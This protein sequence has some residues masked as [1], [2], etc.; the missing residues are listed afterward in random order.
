M[1]SATRNTS[2]AITNTH[3][4]PIIMIRRI[5]IGLMGLA[6]GFGLST[7]AGGVGSMTVRGGLQG[8]PR[9]EA[10]AQAVVRNGHLR[11]VATTSIVGDVVSRVGGDAVTI[12]VLIGPGRDPHTYEPTPRGMA[13][14]S[15]ADMV[16]ANGAGLEDDLADALTRA[17]HGSIVEVSDGVPLLA[18]DHDGDR[19]AVGTQAVESGSVRTPDP[20]T[21]MS[22]PNV[23]IWVE[24]IRDAL[25]TMDPD[26][27]HRYVRNAEEYTRE[28]DLLDQWIRESVGVVDPARRQLVSDH[29]VFAYFADEY[30]FREMGFVV[31]GA[32][33][34]SEVSS[35]ALADLV[36]LIRDHRITSIFVGVSAGDRMLGLVEAVAAETGHG[37][38]VV[39]I[40]SG[41]LSIPGQPGD[42]YLDFMRLN[43]VRIVDALAEE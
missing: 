25:S 23:K 22:P 10:P 29:R 19:I 36:E 15:D 34:G 43:V 16:F 33:T 35:A 32:S 40:Q 2:C 30:G 4:L 1:L 17:A 8:E 12:N 28:L 9:N 7:W 42:T 26:N 27:A 24:T 18:I 41:G 20:H 11:V 13:L 31:P 6:L 3:D 5:G 21:W 38:A 14:V 39:P 37:V